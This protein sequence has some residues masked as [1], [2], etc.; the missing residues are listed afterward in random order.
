MPKQKKSG[1]VSAPY[2]ISNS[3]KIGNITIQD[4]DETILLL[5]KMLE[6]AN[7]R[8]KEK[9]RRIQELESV[10]KIMAKNLMSITRQ[11]MFHLFKNK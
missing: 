4:K 3:G 6:D 11:L 2:G 9:E 8:L 7:E 5:Q 1:E 10:N